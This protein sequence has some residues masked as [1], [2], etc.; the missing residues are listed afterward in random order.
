[1][2]GD[3]CC[4]GERDG[5]TVNFRLPEY[6]PTLSLMF[7]SGSRHFRKIFRFA[8]GRKTLIN[9]MVGGRQQTTNNN[10]LSR[11]CFRHFNFSLCYSNLPHYRIRCVI[12]FLRNRYLTL[13]LKTTRLLKIVAITIAQQYATIP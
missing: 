4:K 9:N 11:S 13:L 10:V 12:T 5:N 6:T 2:D 3:V 7:L 8:Y 1:M